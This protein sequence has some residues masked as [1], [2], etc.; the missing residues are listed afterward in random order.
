V[1]VRLLLALV[2]CLLICTALADTRSIASQL[3]RPNS[4]ARKRQRFRDAG[5]RRCCFAQRLQGSP[6]IN[7]L[8]IKFPGTDGLV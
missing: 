1:K 6:A 5:E 8:D 3:S 7:E 4:M 2:C